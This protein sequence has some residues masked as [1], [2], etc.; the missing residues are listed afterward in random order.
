MKKLFCAILIVM[1]TVTVFGAAMAFA[2][3]KDGYYSVWS[4]DF[5]SYDEGNFTT[6]TKWPIVNNACEIVNMGGQHGNVL[7]AI[8]NWDEGQGRYT[9]G[10]LFCTQTLTK[11]SSYWKM[12]ADLYF[13]EYRY[14]ALSAIGNAG[15]VDGTNIFFLTFNNNGTIVSQQ[16]GIPSITYQTKT[17]YTVTAYFDFSASKFSV[18]IKGGNFENGTVLLRGQSFNN[19]ENSNT[20][21][22]FRIQPGASN[23]LVALYINNVNLSVLTDSSYVF[24]SPYNFDVGYDYTIFEDD[25]DVGYEQAIENSG[26]LSTKWNSGH[27]TRAKLKPESVHGFTGRGNIMQ[28]NN[29]TNIQILPQIGEGLYSVSDLQYVKL[30]FDIRFAENNISRTIAM[31][32]DNTYFFALKFENNNTIRYYDQGVLKNITDAIYEANVWYT[33]NLYFDSESKKYSGKI[34]DGTNTWSFNDSTIQFSTSDTRKPNAIY[35]FN[36]GSGNGT[37]GVWVDNVKYETKAP[38]FVPR[39]KGSGEMS[40]S[41]TIRPKIDEFD[42]GTLIMARYKDDLLIDLQFK[43]IDASSEGI[44]TETVIINSSSKEETVKAFLWDGFPQMNPLTGI[45][46]LN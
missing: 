14:V 7:S 34:T 16:G 42:K 15:G 8:G 28:I 30:S 18:I 11:T 36:I 41:Y 12:E 31:Y 9:A 24:G 25:F 35:S 21:Q 13:E 6:N 17:W 4:D 29:N 33:V 20:L 27:L 26:L 37:A 46:K 22:S 38:G 5:E 32:D 39:L 40:V 45:L 44:A 2:S 1:F 19:S 43:P 3:G 10:N 23:P